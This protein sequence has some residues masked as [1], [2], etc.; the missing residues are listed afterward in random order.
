M[1]NK[2]WLIAIIIMFLAVFLFPY[3]GIV[4]GAD[5]TECLTRGCTGTGDISSTEAGIDWTTSVDSVAVAESDSEI[6]WGISKITFDPKEDI[7]IYE[8]S[9][10]VKCFIENN[11]YCDSP[12]KEIER[13][14]NEKVIC[15]GPKECKEMGY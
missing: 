7:T 1:P 3:W 15:T 10:A 13:H 5:W 8:L 14:F 4:F 6:T 12:P 11:N 2:H 9:L